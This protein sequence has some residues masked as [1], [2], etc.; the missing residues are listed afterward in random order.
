MTDS[1]RTN[2]VQQN[3]LKNVHLNVIHT[4]TASIQAID[5]VGQM[6]NTAG[7][8]NEKTNRHKTEVAF[9][10]YLL[11]FSVDASYVYFACRVEVTFRVA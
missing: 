4:V 5:P 6:R 7:V 11:L 3:C 10:Q 2:T 1:E 8:T 9:L